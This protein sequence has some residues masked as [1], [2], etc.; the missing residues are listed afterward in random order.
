MYHSG[1]LVFSLLEDRQYFTGSSFNPISVS[2]SGLSDTNTSGTTTFYAECSNG[3]CRAATNFVINA[4]PV[5]TAT[6]GGAAIV[7]QV[8]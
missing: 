6:T 1:K 3:S 4:T 2:G 5:I 8:L 7:D